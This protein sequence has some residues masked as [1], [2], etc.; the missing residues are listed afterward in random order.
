MFLGAHVEQQE[1]GTEFVW[2]DGSMLSYKNQYSGSPGITRCLIVH[3]NT[4]TGYGS[5]VQKT[6]GDYGCDNKMSA[7]VCQLNFL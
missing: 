3:G 2:N 1:S 5:S 4:L 6:W 7:V